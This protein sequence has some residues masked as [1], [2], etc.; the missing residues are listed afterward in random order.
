MV[1]TALRAVL[2]R[3]KLMMETGRQGITVPA[4]T[5]FYTRRMMEK[6]QGGSESPT[7]REQRRRR[8]RCMNFI[9]LSGKNLNHEKIYSEYR[10]D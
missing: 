5:K 8:P 1:R 7:N 2:I 6:E 9:L 3:K 10:K 4:R